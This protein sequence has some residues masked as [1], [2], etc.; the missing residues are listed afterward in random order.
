MSAT[1]RPEVVDAMLRGLQPSTTTAAPLLEPTD[2]AE[3]P[4]RGDVVRSMVEGL[5]EKPAG[6]MS[7]LAGSVGRGFV[8]AAEPFAMGAAL[9]QQPGGAAAVS[10]LER[11]KGM[12]PSSS[13][14]GDLQKVAQAFDNQPW[15]ER[16][17]NTLGAAIN[18]PGGTLQMTVESLPSMLTTTLPATAAG[19]AV[20]GPFG[21][22]VG[23]GGASFAQDATSTIIESFREQGVDVE[24]PA[25]M[26][27]ALRDPAKLKVA[28]AS[29]LKH[30]IP[31]ALFDA[32][33]FGLLGHL[34]PMVSKLV[35]SATKGT[36]SAGARELAGKAAEVFGQ[37]VMGG[38]GELAG[39]IAQGRD[40]TDAL[41]VISEFAGEAVG[42]PLEGGM[43][44]MTARK[45]FDVAAWV[46]ANPDAASAVVDRP[47]SRSSFENAGL[48]R[49]PAELRPAI[50]NAIR[51][52]VRPGG[53]PDGMVAP[54]PDDPSR[55]GPAPLAPFD[56]PEQTTGAASDA[57]LSDTTPASGSLQEPAAT[58]EA[59]PPADAVDEPGDNQEDDI[60]AVVKLWN[61]GGDEWTPAQLTKVAEAIFEAKPDAL[62][63]RKEALVLAETAR[64]P[65]IALPTRRAAAQ[66]LSES[67]HAADFDTDDYLK[68][69]STAPLADL[70]EHAAPIPTPAPAPAE[71]PA[72]PIREYGDGNLVQSG[73]GTLRHPV[74]GEPISAEVFRG[75]GRADLNDENASGDRPPIF[76]PGYYYSFDKK[77]ASR[78]GPTIERRTVTLKNPLVITSPKELSD[79][80]FS[81]TG[82]GAS[83]ATV[84]RDPQGLQRLA[85][86]AASKGFDGIVVSVPDASQG[87]VNLRGE[88]AKQLRNLFE[89]SQIFVPAPERPRGASPSPTPSPTPAP[90]PAS[91][92]TNP[93]P[94][95]SG[96]KPKVVNRPK[97]KAAPSAFTR[98]DL[99]S[100]IIRA[101]ESYGQSADDFA[102]IEASGTSARS[103]VFYKQLPGE[104]NDYL[105]GNP[106]ARRWVSVTDKVNEAG[107]ADSMSDLGDEYFK[108]LDRLSGKQIESA[109]DLIRNAPDP[110]H[111]FLA[112]IHDNLPPG[113]Q[114]AKEV[115]TPSELPTGATFTINKERFR[116]TEDEQGLR[117]LKDGDQYP[118]V[119]IDYLEQIPLD[120]GSLTK[121][122]QVSDATA[123]SQAKPMPTA[124]DMFGR[125][126]LSQPATGSQRGL[127]IGPTEGSTASSFTPERSGTDRAIADK[128]DETAT[129][130]IN[131]DEIDDENDTVGGVPFRTA[132]N[133]LDDSY[134]GSVP[135]V[136]KSDTARPQVVSQHW[137][138]QWMSKKFDVPIRYGE[139]RN[140]KVLGLYKVKGRIIRANARAWGNLYVHG[141]ELAHHIDESM[142]LMRKLSTAARDE[143][144][145]LDYDTDLVAQGMGRPDEGFA[146]YMARWWLG[147]DLAVSA[148][149]F[150]GE[151][152]G[153]ILNQNPEMAQKVNALHGHA[154]AYFAQG[155]TDRFRAHIS[156]D[157]AMPMVEPETFWGKQQEK[158]GNVWRA[159]R[160]HVEDDALDVAAFQKKAE[161]L[162]ANMPTPILDIY[163]QSHRA[164]ARWG[165]DAFENGVF[166]LSNYDKKRGTK[167]TEKFSP[168]R[169]ISPGFKQIMSIVGDRY[170]DWRDFL[171][172]RHARDRHARGIATGFREDETEA[173]YQKHKDAP[174]FEEA[175]RMFT[176]LNNALVVAY[177]KAGLISRSSAKAMLRSW[178]ETYIPMMKVKVPFSSGT[179][180]DFRQKMGFSPFRKLKGSGAQVVDPIAA[181]A[182][183]FL[184]AYQNLAHADFN[185]GVVEAVNSTKGLGMYAERMSPKQVTIN[186]HL[187]EI[188]DQ[189]AEAGLDKAAIDDVL[190]NG[191]GDGFMRIFR[192]DYFARL[193]EPGMISF[194]RDG[195][196]D[197]ELWRLD[198]N[199][200]AAAKAIAPEMSTDLFIKIA[201]AFTAVQRV[202]AVPLNLGFVLTNPIRDYQTYAWQGEGS[203]FDRAIDPPKELLRRARDA[204]AVPLKLRD[205]D[206]TRELFEFM[207]ASPSL[208]SLG[209]RP[210][211]AEIKASLIRGN[212]PAAILKRVGTAPLA[213]AVKMNEELESIPRLAAF[214]HVLEAS[215]FDDVA[216]RSGRKPPKDVLYAAAQAAAESTVD[217]SRSGRWRSLS[218]VLLFANAIVQSNSRFI[219]MWSTPEG[220][221][222]AIPALA[223]QAAATM[224]YW[225]R[226]KDEP[227]YE[228]ADPWAKYYFWVFTDDKGTPFLRLPMS[229]ET[230]SY[231]S[232][233]ML[234]SLDALNK[235]DITPLLQWTYGT[236][237][238]LWAKPSIGM[239]GF[240]VYANWDSFRD[241]QI[242]PRGLEDAPAYKQY[243]PN[244]TITA[245]AIGKQLGVSPA[246]LEYL[247]DGYTGGLF[248]RIV[249]GGE[250]ALTDEKGT[251]RDV[252]F[253]S[254][255]TFGSD[256]DG[257]SKRFYAEI[258]RLRVKKSMAEDA[259]RKEGP[260]FDKLH[261][262][263][264]YRDV[265]SAVRKSTLEIRGR[266]ERMEA[267][268]YLIG[269]RRRAL[270]EKEL[271]GRYPDPLRE[272]P[273]DANVKKAIEDYLGLEL[274][275]AT[276]L[277]PT[278]QPTDTLEDYKAKVEKWRTE[279]GRAK[280]LIAAC[281]WP[282]EDL[283]KI[284]ITKSKKSNPTV[285]ISEALRQRL[286]SLEGLSTPSTP[287]R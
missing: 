82:K 94:A 252:P 22:A 62:L 127:A 269:L 214:R 40:T 105:Q 114:P 71:V 1:I 202:G 263:E 89:R 254:N 98:A 271:P 244:T 168:A 27:M 11:A 136:P 175:A 180:S 118:H 270:G 192:A 17:Y 30:G 195:N 198:D 212:S 215:G 35:G 172:A 137:I 223:F 222:R 53:R 188:R 15:Y 107:G 56:M 243:G 4:I 76:G 16:Y 129:D 234:A 124:T 104:M 159:F 97:S 206:P 153:K 54:N 219:R 253:V 123:E 235:K 49:V 142:K 193:K 77:E 154:A 3:Q 100:R 207:H 141:H 38:G 163:R 111:Q 231:V 149:T 47:A 125:P 242:V 18:N 108:I 145:M 45:P 256:P 109:K 164:A 246:K 140:K 281:E 249:R 81:A 101:A 63:G 70:K 95:A 275:K 106:A 187:N 232:G 237:N 274:M 204:F 37:G 218:Q 266:D 191:D 143:L 130:A 55:P 229:Y 68:V 209:Y 102:K 186:F 216:L 268:K 78:F 103:F 7:G 79:F 157:G 236:L 205:V 41:S 238:K 200:A 250:L 171:I 80:N 272:E 58:S 115:V 273:A 284:L 210:G 14:V 99:E 166:L 158:L 66:L 283:S 170:D 20:A 8:N 277:M 203:V 19:G 196:A 6:F 162:G 225:L 52:M 72:K 59:P 173:M 24:N 199:L 112:A 64:R 28:G 117:I 174:G 267:E 43:K 73:G 150:T 245:R 9:T 260:E 42:T 21:A 46:R 39:Q 75:Y 276:S 138:V 155:F 119:P 220:R 83:A 226:V 287:R 258:D 177:V 176:R 92:A 31:V 230:G 134:R 91:A 247:V 131:Y 224:L 32:F 261:E 12:L 44:S 60:P 233:S 10:M 122:K 259:G 197:P 139:I 278:R 265:M 57:D 135:P 74:T 146:E 36:A 85:Q 121:P 156:S 165:M 84:V 86:F 248:R 185:R 113:R 23:A 240:D 194:Y 239:T 285:G 280:Q 147:E 128:F 33:S 96:R 34:Q 50:L 26:F 178:G 69:A 161:A 179:E 279:R 181:T 213:A 48:P 88:S 133:P 51:E 208:S 190:E 211:A 167:V 132:P 169:R 13:H 2:S 152:F 90:T 116:V 61:D 87:D 227:W 201:G 160:M 67:S 25:E 257:S 110:Q 182:W 255:I 282:E 144:A 183:R 251:M 151:F 189:L 65:E 5:K 286:Q 262:L 221:K 126:D 148:P 120:K 217:F 29:A 241:R 184:A 228:N 93:P 264:R